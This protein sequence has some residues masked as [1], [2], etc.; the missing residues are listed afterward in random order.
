MECVFHLWLWSLNWYR[1]IHLYS[2]SAMR[3]IHPSRTI[4]TAVSVPDRIHR[5]FMFTYSVAHTLKFTSK[6]N[7]KLQGK[8]FIIDLHLVDIK[9]FFRNFIFSPPEVDNISRF[10]SM[11]RR[12][13]IL[14]R[15]HMSTY[16]CQ[17]NFESINLNLV[18]FSWLCLQSKIVRILFS[19]P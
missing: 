7:A 3:H 15:Y 16:K 17:T 8:V 14:N 2:W 10:Q 13:S 11:N 12:T 18:Y 6:M 19:P 1:I 9:N 5:E 4:F